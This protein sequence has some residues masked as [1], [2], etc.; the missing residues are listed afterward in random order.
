MQRCEKQTAVATGGGIGR[1]TCC[2]LDKEGQPGDG[3]AELK[4]LRKP[5]LCRFAM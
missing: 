5:G 3:A 1:S 2:W 4:D